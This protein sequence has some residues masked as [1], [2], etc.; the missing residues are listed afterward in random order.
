MVTWSVYVYTAERVVES[1]SNQNSLE[2]ALSSN[3]TLWKENTGKSYKTAPRK[4]ENAIALLILSDGVSYSLE[5]RIFRCVSYL[6]LQFPEYHRCG[7]HPIRL[8][9]ARTLANRVGSGADQPGSI[10]WFS[11]PLTTPGVELADCWGCDLTQSV[12]G[13]EAFICSEQSER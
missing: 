8:L 12:K 4:Q 10:I 7:N 5:P 6:R 2:S 11:R 1:A 13:V 3:T 9:K